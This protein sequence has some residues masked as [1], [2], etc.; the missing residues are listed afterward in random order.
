MTGAVDPVLKRELDAL[1]LPGLPVGHRV[2]VAGDENAFGCM[3]QV[4]VSSWASHGCCA[5]E[6][7]GSSRH[8]GPE[9]FAAAFG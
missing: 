7:M 4:E 5:V 6:S 2:I 3:G 9:R 1:A 8:D